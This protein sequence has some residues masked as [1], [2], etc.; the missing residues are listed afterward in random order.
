MQKFIQERKGGFIGIILAILV[1]IFILSYFNVSVRSVFN[2]IFENKLFKDNLG[3]VWSG[4]KN[5][6]NNYLEN[7]VIAFWNF[8]KEKSGQI[9]APRINEMAPEIPK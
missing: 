3:Y 6:W 9:V 1:I 8:I 7:P 5:I 2:S 4:L